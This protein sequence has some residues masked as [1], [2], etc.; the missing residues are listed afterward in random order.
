MCVYML[1]CVRACVRVC[2]RVSVCVRANVCA[3]FDLHKDNMPSG[4]DKVCVL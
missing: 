4:S 1:V 3:F 2:V